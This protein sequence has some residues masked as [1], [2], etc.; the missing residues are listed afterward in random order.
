MGL[1]IES[2]ISCA[3]VIIL[4][5]YMSLCQ[6]PSVVTRLMESGCVLCMNKKSTFSL[7]QTPLDFSLV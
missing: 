5:M 1:Q 4:D 2:A 3:N 6:A 7:H